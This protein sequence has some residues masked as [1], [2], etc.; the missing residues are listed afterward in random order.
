MPTADPGR[1]LVRLGQLAEELGFDAFFL[2]DH[3]ANAPECWLHLCAIAVS[4]KRVRLGPLVAAVSYR[5]PVLTALLASDLDHLSDGRLVLGLG[6]GWNRAEYGLGT[7]EFGQLGLAYPSV[8]DRQASLEEAIAVIR[9]V[10]SAETPFSFTGNHHQAEGAQVAIP[11]QPGGPPLIVAGAGNRTLR[12]VAR[13]ADACNFGGG[14]AGNVDTPDQARERL[15]AL[16]Q[17]CAEIGRSYDDI[18]KTHFTHWVILAPDEEEATA[19]LR[20]YFPNGLD[21]FWGQSLVWGTPEK[22][23]RHYGRFVEVGIQYFVVQTVDPEDIETIGMF[24]DV[25]AAMVVDRID[26]NS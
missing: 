3:P 17:F 5:P 19:K 9:G 16:R 6:I 7:N 20:R 24:A 14:P 18:L 13:A 2:G 26:P 1:Q 8:A 23:A 21:S 25:V 10:W 11:C 15:A 12:L 22:V 4:T